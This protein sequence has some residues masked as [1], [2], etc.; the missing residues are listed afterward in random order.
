MNTP[1]AASPAEL[2]AMLAKPTPAYKR[3]AWL[4]GLALV[5]FVLLYLLLAAAFCW[6]AWRLTFGGGAGS[7]PFWSVVIGIC[8]ALLAVFML[9]ALVFVKRGST[10]GLTLI[11]AGEQPQLFAFLHE[12]ADKAGAPRPHKVFVSARV[13][14]A[15]FY[16]L[17]LLNLL[18][19]SRKNLE[20]GLGLV[21]V[22]SLG[23]LRAVLA[24]EF[25]HFAQRSMAVGRWVY[26]AQQ[27]AAHVV[28]R[29]DALDEFLNWLS[30]VDFRVAWVGWL[31]RLVVW[32][33]RSLVET[34]FRMVVLVERALS[35]EME[36]NADLVAVSLT[37]SDALVHALHKL[38]GADDAWDR[39]VGFVFGQKNRQRV[40]RDLFVVHTRIAQRM[41]EILRDPGYASAPAMPLGEPHLHRVFR[42]EFA[43]PPRMWSTHPLNHER[44]ANAKRHYIAAPIDERSA[45]GLFV[46]EGQLRQRVTAQLL[47]AG[48][49]VTVDPA[50]TLAEVDRQFDREC[51]EG[52]YRGVY[53]GRTVVRSAEHVSEL[54][55]D[56]ARAD[57]AALHALYPESL[58]GDIEQMRILEREL[59]QLRALHLGTL[60]PPDG[61]IRHRERRLNAQQLPAVID[62]VRLELAAVVARLEAHDKQCRSVH[63]ALARRFV[64]LD[65][66]AYLDGLLRALHYADHLEA[67]LRDAQRSLANT[68]RIATAARRVSDA[69]RKRILGAAQELYRVLS[70]VF[71]DRN[72]V[73]LDA[74]LL[75]RLGV[76]SWAAAMGSCNL[77][78]PAEGLLGDWL[79]AVDS[80]VDHAAGTCGGLRAA[81][82]DELLATE[83]RVADWA[84]QVSSR[85][86]ALGTPADG[87]VPNAPPPGPAP[88]PSIVPRGSLLV[89][90]R[91]RPLQTRLDWW[92]RFQTADGLLPGALRLT[93]AGSIVVAVLGLAITVGESK[94]TVYNGLARAVDVTIG[95]RSQRVAAHASAEISVAS[96][97]DY[98]VET[99]T[100]EGE[101]I[102]AFDAG[103][104]GSSAFVYNVASAAPLL[105]W[106]AVYGGGSP[107]PERRLGAPRWSTPDVDVLFAEPPRTVSSK[108]RKTREVLA[109][110]DGL[111]VHQQLAMAGTDEDRNRLAMA[112]V[113]WDSLT[114][115]NA[116]LWHYAASRQ[117]EYAQA[118]AMRLKQSPENVLLL[119]LEQDSASASQRPAVCERHRSAAAAA[120]DQANL[121]YAAI[122]CIEDKT[123]R[124]AGFASG[125][126]RWPDHAWFS[127]AAAY[128]KAEQQRWSSA[129]SLL[130]TASARDPVLGPLSA[131][132]IARM[133]RVQGQAALPREL[134]AQSPQLQFLNDA[135]QDRPE[136]GAMRAY[137]LLERGAL[138]LALAVMQPD[139]ASRL[140]LLRLAAA[141]TGADAQLQQRALALPATQGVDHASAVAAAGLALRHGRDAS[142]Y[143][144]VLD[145][146][147]RPALQRVGAA[148][149]SGNV[150]AVER[151]LQ[152]LMPE[153]RGHALTLGAV[154]MGRQAPAS[155][156]AGSMALLFPTERPYFN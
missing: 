141:S 121:Q 48:N 63:R 119:R 124:D 90:G 7:D 38:Q 13:N 111:G 102:E 136:G 132:D 18:L 79:Q 101:L 144:L 95:K 140:R 88:A 2:L 24:H 149:T 107:P 118:L 25:G 104:H 52:R 29:R 28:A 94:I 92:S 69:G 126:K 130:E 49:A 81:A 96:D 85:E 78:V 80:W 76:E 114:D 125:Y 58:T 127:F 134:L 139:E 39:S 143:F 73:K 74:A 106:T 154:V 34:V 3:Q 44:E 116:A 133:R 66:V 23:E 115:R 128:G 97:T 129:V 83:R 59:D 47:G 41:R 120:P 77:P 17:S 146:Q 22:L 93:V 75:Q 31:L 108:G 65:W 32:A 4:A 43:Q 151:E 10:E 150:A 155:W 14:A 147:V 11:K 6:S 86:S 112:H 152:G 27:V 100:A 122:R 137:A 33:I 91:E 51:F 98:R 45:W 113:R 117:P 70:P 30:R 9:K 26:V 46:E 5:S 84:G 135:A 8:S 16:D 53:L 72:Q 105:Q 145:D 103:V 40:T 68:M 12:L 87:T 1:A 153:V 82:L 123:A 35:R 57:R 156:R 56:D 138:D 89:P 142:P 64:G 37:G 20:I 67:D 62:L 19:P 61:V 110:G 131:L 15:V 99:R 50:E 71:A 148:A 54:F 60:T 55:E 21:N 36:M 42:Q 109:A